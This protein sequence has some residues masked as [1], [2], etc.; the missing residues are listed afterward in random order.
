[1][2]HFNAMEKIKELLL[3]H[4]GGENATVAETAY[5]WLLHHSALSGE[6]GDRIVIGKFWIIFNILTV[7][8][9]VLQELSNLKLTWAT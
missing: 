3:K 1:V 7:A 2:E 4:H 6:K 5:R 9:Q 8:L